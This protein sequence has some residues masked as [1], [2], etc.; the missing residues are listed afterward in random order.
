[1]RAVHGSVP[2]T[3]PLVSVVL[4]TYNRLSYLRLA[5]LT[6]LAQTYDNLEII[7]QDNA[8]SENPS[9]LVAAFR[10]PRMQL[11]RC[12]CNVSQTENFLAGIARATGR[13]IAILADDDLWRPNFIS[14]LVAAMELHPDAVVAFCDH[15]IIDAEGRR[16][17]A[18]TKE[19][20]RRFGRHR[21]CPGVHQPFD[22]IALVYR[23]ICVVSG[24]LIHRDAID[25]HGIPRDITLGIDM[26][27][28]YLLATSGRSC[29]YADER[30]ARV[31]Y[32]PTQIGRTICA[33]PA[34][35]EWGLAFWKACLEDRRIGH[36][37]YYKMCCARAAIEIVLDRFRRRDWAGLRE[38][39]EVLFRMG[40]ID[41]RVVLYLLGYLLR[42][43]LAGMR[44]RLP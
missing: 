6:V 37:A 9:A 34:V 5:L 21:L 35:A 20:T 43:R 10:D 7:V 11:Y 8:S 26:Y 38:K 4:P 17:A 28:A 44:R 27:I 36:H 39:L 18:Q 33:D 25:W 12:P 3:T 31:R 24:A 14:V 41:P 13:Y 16:D 32:H 23:S 40:L 2:A 30:L 22:D 15:D 42:F 29:W 1:M 19:I